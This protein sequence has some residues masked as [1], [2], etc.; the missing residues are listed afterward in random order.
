MERCCQTALSGSRICGDCQY[1]AT[2]RALHCKIAA[3]GFLE[4]HRLAKKRSLHVAIRSDQS[5]RHHLGE[6][7]RA[8][9]IDVVSA[10]STA[11]DPDFCRSVVCTKY[12]QRTGQPFRLQTRYPDIDGWLQCVSTV[13][14]AQSTSLE[15]PEW[16]VPHRPEH[17][18]QTST[19]D[20]SRHHQLIRSKR[21]HRIYGICAWLSSLGSYRTTGIEQV[22]ERFCDDQA[23]QTGEPKEDLAVLQSGRFGIMGQPIDSL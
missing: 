5:Q 18:G 22:Q 16:M 10:D 21:I 14:P 23:A 1:F 12:L 13:V 19:G 17:R 4:R 7:R 11:S 9:C 8:I 2:I 6:W 20:H 15:N 3:L